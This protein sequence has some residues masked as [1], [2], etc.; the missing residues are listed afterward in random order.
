[1][2]FLSAFMLVRGVREVLLCCWGVVFLFGEEYL[3]DFWFLSETLR[4]VGLVY[5]SAKYQHP[6]G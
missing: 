1:M 6:G 2:L 3:T 4:R 5:G